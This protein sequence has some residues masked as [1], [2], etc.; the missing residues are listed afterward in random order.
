MLPLRVLLA[1]CMIFSLL[2]L[3]KCD[4][5]GHGGNVGFIR[6]FITSDYLYSVADPEGG[7]GA[8]AP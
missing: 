1:F 7:K 2:Q 6:I 3:R 4:S 8:L 5:E